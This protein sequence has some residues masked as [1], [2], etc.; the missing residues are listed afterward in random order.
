MDLWKSVHNQRVCPHCHP[1]TTDGRQSRTKAFH[2]KQLEL[3]TNS[4]LSTPGSPAR[5]LQ[6]PHRGCVENDGERRGQIGVDSG[7]SFEGDGPSTR[8]VCDLFVIHT[9]VHSVDSLFRSAICVRR[10][11]RREGL[12]QRSPSGG[13]WPLSRPLS[14]MPGSS[15]SPTRRVRRRAGDSGVFPIACSTASGN[16][17][18]CAVDRTINGDVSPR[19]RRRCAAVSPTAVCGSAT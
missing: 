11:D 16:L 6:S 19:W 13:P 5:W 9:G 12:S 1:Q 7:L 2:V 3:S 8:R 4:P 18:G 15:P 17:A 14:P 10:L